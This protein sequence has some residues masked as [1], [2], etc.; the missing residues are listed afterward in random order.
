VTHGILAPKENRVV[1]RGHQ[2]QSV[3]R[4]GIVDVQVECIGKVTESVRIEGDATI[5]YEAEILV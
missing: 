2:G 1:F 3:R 5:V 4:P